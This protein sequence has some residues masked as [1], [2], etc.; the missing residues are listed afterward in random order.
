MNAEEFQNLSSLIRQAINTR[1]YTLA[2]SHMF[3]LYQYF[4]QSQ[5]ELVGY[6]NSKKEAAESSEY[7]ARKWFEDYKKYVLDARVGFQ[8][9]KIEKY[10]KDYGKKFIT[11]EGDDILKK[12]LQMKNHCNNFYNLRKKVKKKKYNIDF[13]E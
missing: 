4:Y 9:F 7:E 10:S 11:A 13:D 8:L 3:T 5:I 12:T 1:N 6:Y 2:L